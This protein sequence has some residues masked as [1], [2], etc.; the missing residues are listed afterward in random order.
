MLERRVTFTS[1]WTWK[2]ALP[3]RSRGPLCTVLRSMSRPRPAGPILGRKD[4]RVRAAVPR[5]CAG[6]A[7]PA[8]L[9]A[10]QLDLLAERPS[11]ERC[12]SPASPKDEQL[13]EFGRGAEPEHVACLVGGDTGAEV[14]SSTRYRALSAIRARRA[15]SSSAW[16]A[17]ASRSVSAAVCRSRSSGE[18]RSDTS[19]SVA[20]IDSH[21]RGL[22]GAWRVGSRL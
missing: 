16:R 20:H 1:E 19:G 15:S 9:R 21:C 12:R 10:H 4:P 5:P 22:G 6:S 14:R 7:D 11:S 18:T 8:S 2:R 17:S 3:P 13:I